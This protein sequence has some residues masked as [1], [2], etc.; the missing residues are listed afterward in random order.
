MWQQP[1]V[2]QKTEEY[3][4]IISYQYHS[5]HLHGGN[6]IAGKVI[7]NKEKPV[8]ARPLRSIELILK[9]NWQTVKTKVE[10]NVHPVVLLEEKVETS[11][12]TVI[13]FITISSFKHL[14]T[15]END[16]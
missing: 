12:H 16:I 7:G 2:W 5:H 15:E 14:K 4:N 10:I 9:P 11:A 13:K 8:E 1:L 6:D 3:I